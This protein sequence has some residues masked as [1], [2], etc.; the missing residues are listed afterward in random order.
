[1]LLPRTIVAAT[2][3][4]ECGQRAVTEAAALAGRL[5]ARLILLH[6]WQVSLASAEGSWVLLDDVYAQ[7][8]AAERSK[9]HELLQQIRA[10]LPN[11]EEMFVVG[12]PRAAIV[13]AARDLQADVIVVGTHGRKGLSR[14]L[15]G[16]VAEWV[17]H[18]APCATWL[19]RDT[20]RPLT[21]AAR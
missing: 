5:G 20:A 3:F 10:E 6:V 16:S 9:L 15:L 2:D 7:L 8:E 19:V 14:V 18:H 21:E 13:A 17:V 12:E 1:M 4:S 11:A